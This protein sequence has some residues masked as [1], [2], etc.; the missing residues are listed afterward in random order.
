MNKEILLVVEAV[1]NEKG[2]DST[3]IFEAIEA[4]LEMATKKRA[5][6]DID[7]KVEI[8]RKTGD[9]QTTRRWLVIPDEAS[10]EEEEGDDGLTKL[11]LSEAKKR[12]P[13]IKVGEYLEEA[14]DSVE[15]LIQKRCH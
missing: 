6:A 3:V 10:T 15:N 7:V 14:V 12:N 2:V 11:T 13:E 5:G 1:S 8:N 9:Y 4:A